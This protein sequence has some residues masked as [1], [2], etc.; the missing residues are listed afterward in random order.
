M[1]ENSQLLIAT[2]KK[3]VKGAADL[4]RRNRLW[5]A[6]LESQ[7]LLAFNA[8]G[9]DLNDVVEFSQPE[10]TTFGDNDDVTYANHSAYK[11]RTTDV[12]G[13][14]MTDMLSLKQFLMN[15][16]ELQIVALYDR[17]S[18]NL[19][20]AFRDKFSKEL[21]VDGNATG[22]DQRFHGINSFMGAGA[23][24][25]GDI[26]AKCDDEYLG[27][28]TA[29]GYYGGTWSTDLAAADR[30]NATLATDW[31]DGNGTT[32][33]DFYSPK[34][35]NASS[36]AWPSG[37]TKWQDNAPDILT[38]IGIWCH[39]TLGDGEFGM[40]HMM[41]THYFQGLARSQSPK[42]RAMVPYT[43]ADLGINVKNAFV[44]D[45]SIIKY[46]FD[47]PADECYSLTPSAMEGFFLQDSLY[48][49]ESFKEQNQQT[50]NMILYSFGNFR[51]MPKYFAKTYAIA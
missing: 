6:M 43:G 23:C 47:C 33:Y 1:A 3:Y 32:E 4:T 27:L 50:Y 37:S 15:R 13:Y 28:Y 24:A 39:S 42:L 11:S 2:A 21:Y 31:P 8:E 17:K 36:T 9:Y 22:N 12:R 45:G 48:T 41:G 20:K 10:M 16:G 40:L 49:L 46:E 44:Y 14:K 35:V 19:E 38:S 26:V 51:W 5:L 18:K 34:L 25:A 30:P 29:Q 7:G